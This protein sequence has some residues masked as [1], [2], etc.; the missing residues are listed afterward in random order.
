MRNAQSSTGSTRRTRRKGKRL[1]LLGGARAPAAPAPRVGALRGLTSPPWTLVVV[2]LAWSGSISC[3]V[4]ALPA[5]E[6]PAHTARSRSAIPPSPAAG[7][8][9]P[10]PRCAA[11]RS[12]APDATRG[13]LLTRAPAAP[14]APRAARILVLSQ[15]LWWPRARKQ[16]KCPQ[17]ALARARGTPAGAWCG[18]SERCQARPASR[19][20]RAAATRRR[21]RR[22]PARRHQAAEVHNPTGAACLRRGAALPSN[23][24]ARWVIQGRQRPLPSNPGSKRF[25]LTGTSPVAPHFL[26][27]GRWARRPTAAEPPSERG[28]FRS[29]AH[30][31][32][33]VLGC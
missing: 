9:P 16:A 18:V 25:F 2:G 14:A 12:R 26:Q 23:P 19:W 8:A 15:V 31:G 3:A 10:P 30:S 7:H 4:V 20:V 32:F 21:R 24:R 5:L 27:P 33:W 11:R 22:K 28:T 1:S 29:L 13:R 17:N 6:A